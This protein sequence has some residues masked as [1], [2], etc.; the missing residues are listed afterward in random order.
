MK[1]R[2]LSEIRPSEFR[3]IATAKPAVLRRR[4]L[5]R[6]ADLLE[7]HAGPIRLFSAIEHISSRR[8]QTMRRDSS[9]FSIAFADSVFRADGLAS[10][11]VG[12]GASF[13]GL[14]SWE[15]HELVCDCHYFG[16]VNGRAVAERARHIAAHP[17][18]ASRFRDFMGD[19]MAW[20]A[21]A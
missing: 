13:F 2:T 11:T 10:D 5:E 12:D 14:S 4:R 3:R 18:L 15:T 17:S 7:D 20:R 1:Y 16:P 19:V 21:S 8:R 6:F 9:P